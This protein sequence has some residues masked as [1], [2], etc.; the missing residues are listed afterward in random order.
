MRCWQETRGRVRNE[1]EGKFKRAKQ[2]AHEERSHILMQAFVI[3]GKA[4]SCATAESFTRIHD[5]YLT[6]LQSKSKKIYAIHMMQ[7]MA[8]QGRYSSSQDMIIQYS[9]NSIF[10]WELLRQLDR[11]L[12]IQDD[13]HCAFNLFNS[14]Q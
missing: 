8:V 1:G 4:D 6:V 10:H 9:I 7:Q 3:F 5:Q 14:I 2:K 12:K 11:C 13:V